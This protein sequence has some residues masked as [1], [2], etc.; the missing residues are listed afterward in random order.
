[1]SKNKWVTQLTKEFGKVASDLPKPSEHVVKMP[2]PSLNWVVGNGGI[3]QGK[4]VCFYGPESSGKSL[5]AQLLMIQLQNDFPDGICIW[6]DAEYSFN[7]E[8]FKK[9]GGDPDRLIVRQT[10]DPLKIFD[11]IGGELHQMIQDGC[12]IVGI[13]VDSIKSIRYPRDIKK[14]TTKQVQ[15]GSGAAYLGSAFKLILPVIREHNITTALVQQVYEEM[16]EYKKM[17]NP[18]I[19]PDGRSLKHFCDYMLEVTRVDTKDGRIEQGTNIYGGAQ[20]VGHK[21]RVKG[22]KNR[23]GAPFRCGEFAINYTQGV[24]NVGEEIYELAKSLGVIY[25][26]INPETGKVNNQMWKFGDLNPVRG[27][28]NMKAVVVGD[29]K[30]QEEIMNTCNGVGDDKV[31][32]RNTELGV[33]DVNLEDAFE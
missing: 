15:G 29:K 9:L 32:A 24:V 4:A 17:N 1:M 18:Y 21:V 7:V 20:Q 3:T 22:K 19:V 25:H 33:I 28:D 16:D 5:L 6:F 13:T 27:D 26:P 10:N 8:W 11:Y 31:V 14:E 30:L 23:V 12:P 2:S